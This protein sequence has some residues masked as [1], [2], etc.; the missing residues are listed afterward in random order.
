VTQVSI[1]IPTLNSSRTLQSC[2][3]A[4]NHIKKP[5]EI[6]SVDGGS[7]DNTLQIISTLGLVSLQ[8]AK[9][10]GLQLAVG[11]KHANSEWLLF[12]HS[13]TVLGSEWYNEVQGFI[14]KSSNNKK[15]AAFRFC[16]NHTGLPARWI[17]TAVHWRCKIFSLP[18]G[19]QGLLI[20]RQFY[21]ELGGYLKIP[22]MEDVELIRKIGR[23]NIS[24][25]KTPALTS[26]IR[27]QEDG[28]LFRPIR[29]LICLV[30]YFLNWD[31]HAINRLYK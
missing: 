27:Y 22:I 15:A 17:E 10:R 31:I 3:S 11:A 23:R 7:E 21:K 26:S 28:W 16:L 1:I 13:D 14:T 4:L 24:M 5:I 12:L 18:Y 9:G 25:L 19:D 29:N 20:N 30:L 6:I 2:V 8:S